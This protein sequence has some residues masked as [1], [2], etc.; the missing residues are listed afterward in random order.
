[1]GAQVTIQ[2]SDKNQDIESLRKKVRNATIENLIGNTLTLTGLVCL[3]GEFL[4]LFPDYLHKSGV[5]Y[6]LDSASQILR[7]GVY[8][9]TPPVCIVGGGWL[10]GDSI[11]KIRKATTKLYEYAKY[12]DD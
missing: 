8:L 9:L 3:M 7:T 2:E 12:R 4:F 11:I 1:M 10:V 5:A 6:E